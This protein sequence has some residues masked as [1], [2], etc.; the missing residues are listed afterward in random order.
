VESLSAPEQ[1]IQKI[2]FPSG[3]RL[4]VKEDHR[5]PFVELRA[6]FQGGVLRESSERNGAT[7]LMAKM[8]LKGTTSRS[9][10]D[11]VRTIEEVG[12]SID[13]Y[14]GNNS[15]GANIEVLSADFAA[16]M[17]VLGDVILRPTFPPD[18]L[19]RERNVQL[20][21]IRAT[22]DHLLQSAFQGMRQKLFAG[23]GY[24]LDPSGREESVKAL[25]QADLCE[26]H[27]TL[28]T[29]KNCV[30]SIFG[31]IDS[32]AAIEATRAAFDSWPLAASPAPLDGQFRPIADTDRIIEPRDKKQAVIVLGFPGLTL[33]DPRRHALE[34]LQEACSDLGSRLFLRIR[35]EL[36]LAYFVGAQNFLGLVPG[37]FAFYAGT[38]P[39]KAAVVEEELK[40]E[41]ELLQSEGLTE[42]ELARAKAKVL[43]QRKIAR[44]DLGHQAMTSALDE[45]YGLGYM[46]SEAED[47][48][49]AAVTLEQIREVA[50]AQLNLRAHVVSIAGQ[51]GAA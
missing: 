42:A 29:P 22:R 23:R 30:L 18:I 32:K 1:A 10:E 44:Q 51:V 12:G 39:E 34:L 41:A 5:L 17:E 11:I 33:N 19:E 36:G 45:L 15:F 13:S 31:D 50:Q 26:L 4:L 8:L 6:V 25:T 43:G 48:R 40:K 49:Y 7:Q 35:E 20:A 21:G 24:G 2:D 3:L 46:H 38:L 37:Y 27:K 47:A 16:A 14:G 28:V 9:A